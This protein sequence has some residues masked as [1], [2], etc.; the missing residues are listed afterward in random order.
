MKSLVHYFLPWE[1]WMEHC[2]P[3]CE[4][5]ILKTETKVLNTKKNKRLKDINYIESIIQPVEGISMG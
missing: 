3:L 2:W 4:M 5:D 1:Y